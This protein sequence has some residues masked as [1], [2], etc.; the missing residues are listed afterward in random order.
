MSRSLGRRCDPPRPRSRGSSAASDSEALPEL[1]RNLAEFDLRERLEI[2]DRGVLGELFLAVDVRERRGH[3]LF[4]KDE[5]QGRL[6]KSHPLSLIDPTEIRGLLAGSL[7]PRR[8]LRLKI[9]VGWKGRGVFIRLE[10]A[11]RV[12]RPDDHALID[13][14]GHGEELA[15]RLFLQDVVVRLDAA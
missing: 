4:R 9:A 10:Y 13:L 8:V 14:E 15:A 12:G 1:L 5:L 2:R 11:A 7:D 3:G 6:R